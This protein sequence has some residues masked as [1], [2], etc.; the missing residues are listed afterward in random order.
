MF[1]HLVP[2]VL[3]VL[4]ACADNSEPPESRPS[5]LADLE[6]H[7]R[8]IEDATGGTVI[9]V[10]ALQTT[11][12]PYAFQLRF[13]TSDEALMSRPGAEP[14]NAAYLINVGRTTAWSTRF[15]TAE[16]KTIMS[17]HRIE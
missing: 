13:K 15:C 11:T 9:F 3:V 6:K 17:R 16:L 1:R 14:G 4:V 10:A 2:F 8:T 12:S 5:P 7:G